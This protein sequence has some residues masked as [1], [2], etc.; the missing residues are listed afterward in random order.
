MARVKRGVM[1]H[2][3]HKK[4]FAQVKGF[5]GSRSRHYK[6]AHEALMHALAYAYRDR[7]NRKRDF[8]RLWIQRINAA[9][10]L[11]G[12]TYSRLVNGLKL[13]QIDL[14]RKIL[15]DM[16][17]RDPAAFANVVTLAN[18]AIKGGVARP[19]R[20][21]SVT[22][23]LIIKAAPVAEEVVV[24]QSI[25]PTPLAS[26]GAAPTVE[27]TPLAAPVATAPKVTTG[28]AISFIEFNPEG[29]DV[30]GEYVRIVNNT[31]EAVE[32]QGWKLRDAGSKHTFTFPSFTLAA[33]AEVQLW[34][35][36]GD[37][38]EGNLYWGNRGAIWNNDGDTALL[39]NADG[40]EVS[41]YTYEGE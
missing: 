22:R 37:N 41:T 16:A 9:A 11:N 21:L 2:K 18:A 34:T 23:P 15:A 32:L 7:R 12:T 24:A 10:R 40:D 28:I 20:E 13:A 39:F 4:L 6:V 8:R 25:A 35:G 29:R 3:R 1:T 30:D 5:R 38:D 33:G 26:L 17:V 36:E 27:A 19:V 31:A 14:D